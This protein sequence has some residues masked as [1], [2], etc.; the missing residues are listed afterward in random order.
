VKISAKATEKI[1]WALIWLAGILAVVFLAIIVGYVL[2]R[3]LRYIDIEFLFTEPGGGLSGEG[4]ISTTIIVTV[5]LVMITMVILIPL[6]VGAAIYL[7]E[8]A[9]RNKITAAIRYSIDLL[10]GVPSVV[11]GLF[12]FAIFVLALSFR[13][14]ILSGALTLVCL[15]IPFL[16]RSAE[17]AIQAVP[18]SLREASL[19]LGAT[20]WQTITNVVLP[21]AIPG[22]V[23]GII[24]CVGRAMAES[25]CLYVTMGGASAMPTSLFSS[26]R[27]MAVHIY[28]LAM[29][30]NALDKAL[31]TGA[32]LIMVIIILN[33]G[34]RWL[35]NYLQ[36]R[37]TQGV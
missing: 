21:A 9:P 15:L 17:E 4:G 26:G 2:I 14:S 29:E 12:G 30:T 11:F 5:I 22:V 37:M 13:Y 10:A 33:M 3:G 20:K 8:Y 31:A 23:T 34:T 19:A 28:Y 32:V 7:S 18:R 25:A 35:S 36:K 16:V 27:T 24:L 1:A 6:G